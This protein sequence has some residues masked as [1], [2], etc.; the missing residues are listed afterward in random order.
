MCQPRQKEAL[1]ND[2]ATM[3][4][5]VQDEFYDGVKWYIKHRPGGLF[6]VEFIA[7]TLQLQHA[8]KH[9]SITKTNTLDCYE[10]LLQKGI[11][12][13]PT[14]KTLTEALVLW[15]NIQGILRLTTTGRFHEAGATTGQLDALLKCTG[16]ANI[17]ALHET[18][19]TLTLQVRNIF[20]TLL[21]K[22]I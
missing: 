2:V 7:Q 5:K 9:P 19:D 10:A 4:R 21:E 14:H 6:D 16:H 1:F 3:R 15:H 13:I 22:E 8:H 11:I 18:M 12:D 17:A 20:N